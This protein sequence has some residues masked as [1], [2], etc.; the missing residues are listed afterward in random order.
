MR[1]VLIGFGLIVLLFLI[2]VAMANPNT[3]LGAVK[4]FLMGAFAD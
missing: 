1:S 4:G 3:M 2:L